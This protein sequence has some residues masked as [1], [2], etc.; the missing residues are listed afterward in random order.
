MF[1]QLNQ[2][3]AGVQCDH[4]VSPD[5]RANVAAVQIHPPTCW[6][7]RLL[8]S[9]RTKPSCLPDCTHWPGPVLRE[10]FLSLGDRRINTL[11]GWSEERKENFV[12]L[13]FF[14]VKQRQSKQPISMVAAKKQRCLTHS[15]S[16]F[17][18]NYVVFSPGRL[19]LELLKD[20]RI[21]EWEDHHFFQSMNVSPQ[22][23][24]LVKFHLEQN[25]ILGEITHLEAAKVTNSKQRI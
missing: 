17:F 22:A 21:Q 6:G 19:N 24:N 3:K 5:Q 14:T 23:A 10:F 18:D 13:F 25:I 9:W 12:L 20:F 15:S 2:Q 16:N 1:R 8:S 4:T 7:S 11:L